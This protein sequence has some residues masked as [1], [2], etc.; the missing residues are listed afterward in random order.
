MKTLN[1]V[2]FAIEFRSEII[3]TL[4]FTDYDGSHGEMPC[5][6]HYM[7]FKES[8]KLAMK[9][10]SGYYYSSYGAVDGFTTDRKTT[11][12]IRK[13]LEHKVRFGNFEQEM[14]YLADEGPYGRNV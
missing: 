14:A 2:H 4:E 7:T 13:Q 8:N 12:S 5:K 3:N 9:A 6:P 10:H 1:Y 11:K